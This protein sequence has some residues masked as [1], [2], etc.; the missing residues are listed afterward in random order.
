[1]A[2][3]LS[4]FADDEGVTACNVRGLRGLLASTRGG[5]LRGIG[6]SSVSRVHPK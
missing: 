2:Q 6:L 4:G 5:I 1:M 3:I